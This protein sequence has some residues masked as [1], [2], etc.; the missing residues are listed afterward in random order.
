MVKGPSLVEEVLVPGTFFKEDVK[1]KTCEA[2]L[3]F[4][5]CYSRYDSD[6]D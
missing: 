2:V 4:E 6:V 3:A 1:A 5:C